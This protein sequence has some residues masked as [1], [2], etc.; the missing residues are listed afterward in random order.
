M[1]LRK[2]DQRA[3]ANPGHERNGAIFQVLLANFDQGPTRE[4]ERFL[5]VVRNPGFFPKVG[6]RTSNC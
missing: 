3:S 6:R 2:H 5:D 4:P 1:S